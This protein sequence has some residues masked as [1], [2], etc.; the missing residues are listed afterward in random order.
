MSKR[1]IGVHIADD[2]SYHPAF[3]LMH[4]QPFVLYTMGNVDALTHKCLGVV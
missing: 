1:G 3:H 4:F 2:A